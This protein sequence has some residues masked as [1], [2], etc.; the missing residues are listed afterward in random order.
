[1]DFEFETLSSVSAADKKLRGGVE[2]A[3]LRDYVE[4]LEKKH[5]AL[6]QYAKSVKEENDLK[7]KDQAD[8]YY[9]LNKK[10]DDNYDTINKLEEQI[11]REQSEREV[12]EKEYEKT[13]E[14][15]TAKLAADEAKFK[16]KIND[17]QDNVDS[18]SEF[19]SQKSDMEKKMKELTKTIESER[20]SLKSRLDDMEKKCI[21]DKSK[22]QRD[23]D[24][25]LEE[26]KKRHQEEIH[27]KLSAK[28]K[29]TALLNTLYKKELSYQ[30]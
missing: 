25:Q 2:V 24:L 7:S 30:V 1:M 18:L 16:Q 10:L 8:I 29:K 5:I 14:Q 9:Y 12:S 23:F 19:V 4:E 26:L 13:I 27:D 17:L 3:S 20:G 15:L 28:A 6:S 22:L 21:Q 11:L